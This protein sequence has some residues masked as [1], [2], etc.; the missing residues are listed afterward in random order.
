MSQHSSAG[1]VRAGLVL[2]KGAASKIPL[3]CKHPFWSRERDC[4]AC[5]DSPGPSASAYSAFCC[6]G[7]PNVYI[8]THLKHIKKNL[9][10]WVD[11]FSCVFFSLCG[12]LCTS[13]T[14][15]S[16]PAA[17]CRTAWEHGTEWGLAELYSKQLIL[18]LSHKSQWVSCNTSLWA[19]WITAS[20]PDTCTEQMTKARCPFFTSRQEKSLPPFCYLPAG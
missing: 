19:G 14:K 15:S 18:Q 10:K 16:L 4:P 12:S 8:H 11:V 2:G 6:T 3:T 13:V 5:L 17:L 20:H 9:L 1:A 7:F